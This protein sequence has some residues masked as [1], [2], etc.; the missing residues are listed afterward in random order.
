M[1][2][3]R[4]PTKN[5]ASPGSRGG[6]SAPAPILSRRIF[7]QLVFF[8]LLLLSIGVGALGGMIFVYSS[9]LPQVRELE[10]YRPDVMTEL[11]ADDGTVIGSFALEHRVIVNYAQIPPVLKDAV[12]SIEDRHFE[13]HWGVDVI[14]IVRAGLTDLFEWK[15]AQ[16]ASTLTQQLSRLLFLTTEKSWRRKFQEML[17]AIQIER[18]FT[19]AQILTMYINIIPLGHG[20]FGFEAA[21][22]F[23]FGKH[24]N[25]LTLPEAALLAGIPRSPTGYSP[26]LRPDRAKARRNLVLAAM[27][28]TGKITREQ[29][30]KAAE[31]PLGLN[32]QHWNYNFAPYFVEEVRQF[33]EK[34]YGSGTVRSKGLKGYTTLNPRSDRNPEQA[35]RPGPPD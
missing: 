23:Y 3:P 28:T 25:E 12:L 22:E 18:Y 19:K 30:V 26:I 14:R 32:I 5:R 21:S 1:P 15:K 10:D 7:G 31:A 9:D 17:V 4:F 13:S 8:T 6:E 35:R 24:L 2:D 16:G 33:L 20:N 27:L 11:Y 34:R 29:Y